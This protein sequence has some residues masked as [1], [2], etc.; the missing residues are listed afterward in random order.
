FS[1][2]RSAAEKDGTKSCGYIALR[3]LFYIAT[4]LHPLDYY[5]GRRTQ[6]FHL[7]ADACTIHFCPTIKSLYCNVLGWH[8]TCRESLPIVPS[9]P[10]ERARHDEST[11]SSAFRI[12]DAFRRYRLG[13]HHNL[14]H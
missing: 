13:D 6:A 11:S 10:Q 4:H 14:H 7:C 1:D 5:P 12:A 3:Y 2:L 9:T 8:F